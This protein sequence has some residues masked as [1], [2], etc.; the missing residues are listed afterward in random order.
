MANEKRLTGP[1]VHWPMSIVLRG[2]KEARQMLSNIGNVL[3]ED[4]DPIIADLEK[5]LKELNHGRN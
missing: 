3:A 4:L 2:L 1:Y 5:Q